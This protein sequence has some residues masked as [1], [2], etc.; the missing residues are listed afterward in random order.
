MK[1]KSVCSKEIAA[2]NESYA[3]GQKMLLDGKVVRLFG[4]AGR[5]QAGLPCVFVCE[6]Q[7]PVLL[8]RLTEWTK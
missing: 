5:T 2:F 1:K 6:Q 3:I 8:D 4:R 7:A